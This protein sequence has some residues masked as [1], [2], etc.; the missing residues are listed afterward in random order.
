M[1][2]RDLFM[3]LIRLIAV[4]LGIDVFYSLISTVVVL[5]STNLDVLSNNKINGINTVL[6]AVFLILLFVYAGKIVDFLKV[7]RGF[8]NTAIATQ[9]LTLSKV[10]QFGVFYIGL[11]MIVNHL[12][13]FLSDAIFWFKVNAIDDSYNDMKIDN[14]WFVAIFNLV[15]GFL[16]LRNT[17]VVADWLIKGEDKV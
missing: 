17:A 3:L 10:A 4:F 12:P 8:S 9:N 15:L 11:L 6:I 2:V 13:S 5:F 16:L 1:E 14:N 7:E